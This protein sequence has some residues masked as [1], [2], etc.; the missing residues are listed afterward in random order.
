MASQNAQPSYSYQTN[1]V[2]NIRPKPHQTPN[3]EFVVIWDTG[4]HLCYFNVEDLLV[5]ER[6]EARNIITAE[7]FTACFNAMVKRDMALQGLAILQNNGDATILQKADHQLPR[8]LPEHVSDTTIRD[9]ERF[10][11]QRFTPPWCFDPEPVYR[12]NAGF[13]IPWYE[14]DKTFYRNRQDLV[15]IEDK[16]RSALQDP[17]STII[18]RHEAAIINRQAEAAIEVLD[19][20]MGYARAAP[21]LEA[22]QPA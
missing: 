21:Q 16:S 15:E 7:S 10:P 17:E 9:A 3:G 14:Q 8:N 4:D 2:L 19:R 5:M 12:P 6:D 20:H 11:E 22:K 13:C 1:G 18:Q